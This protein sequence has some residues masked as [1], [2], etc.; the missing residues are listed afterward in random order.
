MVNTDAIQVPPPPSLVLSV[1]L[2]SLDNI[3]TVCE[4]P[5]VN[6]HGY[7]RP[8]YHPH[9][10]GNFDDDDGWPLIDMLLV[11]MGSPSAALVYTEPQQHYQ[12]VFDAIA[13]V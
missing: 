5:F 6:K 1:R 3:P 7:M 12:E 4:P 2:T 13:M 9:E 8:C 11:Q 10:P